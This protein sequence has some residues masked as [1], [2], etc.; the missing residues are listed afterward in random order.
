MDGARPRANPLRYPRGTLFSV[1]TFARGVLGTSALAMGLTVGAL[2][3]DWPLAASQAGKAYPR[4]GFRCTAVI[5][6]TL[7]SVGAAPLLLV[8]ADSGCR[9]ATLGRGC[10]GFALRFAAGGFA[11]RRELRARVAGQPV[12]LQ[13]ADIGRAAAGR[14]EGA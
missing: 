3:M 7:G 8:D 9:A 12:V 5:G 14:E 11:A 1:P 6:S 10:G 13:P 4:I 2:T